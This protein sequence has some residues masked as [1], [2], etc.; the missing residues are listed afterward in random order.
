MKDL[1]THKCTIYNVIPKNGNVAAVYGN[2][3]VV[4]RC[5]FEGNTISKI[6]G[7]IIQNVYSKYFYTKDIQHYLPPLWV[8]GGYY[9]LHDVEKANYFT[10]AT[11]DII[12]LAE[13]NDI[14][15]N[16]SQFNDLKTKYKDQIIIVTSTGANINGLETDH[17]MA[18][19]A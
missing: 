1:F 2:M 13:V 16:S 8:P 6:N 15:A 18:V 10:V 11:G 3:R 5:F 19:N 4:D 7:T 9:S 17:I 14:V 12:I